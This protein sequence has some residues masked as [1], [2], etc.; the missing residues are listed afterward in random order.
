MD[1]RLSR[2]GFARLLGAGLTLA[3]APAGGC[4][5]PRGTGRFTGKSPATAAPAAAPT[6]PVRLN[7]NE[8]PYGPSPAALDAIRE[9]LP[10]AC[11]YPDEQVDAL[12]AA[13][14]RHHQLDAEHVLI[15][16]GSSEVLRLAVAAAG[17]PAVVMADPS[18]EAVGA[19]ARDTGIRVVKVPLTTDF[20]HDLPRMLEGAKDGG[21]V[22]VCNPNNPTASVTP[23]AEL[24][25]FLAAVPP[26]AVVL[27]DEAYHHFASGGGYETV[28]PLVASLPNLIVSRTFSKIYGMAGLRCGYAVAPPALLERLRAQ[29]AWDSPNLVGVVAAAAGL[30]DQAYVETSRLRNAA[31]RDRCVAALLARRLR[32]IPSQAN[33][34]MVDLGTEVRPVIAALRERG[35][36]VGRFFPGLPTHLRVTV[37][38]EGEMVRFLDAFS[39]VLPAAA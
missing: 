29:K 4:A 14:G 9:A 6:G 17:R 32:V 5:S 30:A 26:S 19:H 3:V 37:G 1:E 35:V 33:F 34:F 23:A 22:Y 8:N 11:R 18:F 36:H 12:A 27:V 20:R 31:A 25:D 15:G 28:V 10:L 21:L 7:A 38:T 39:S 2:R 13:L 24:R 16:S